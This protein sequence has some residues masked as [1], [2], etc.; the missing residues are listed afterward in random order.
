MVLDFKPQMRIIQNATHANTHVVDAGA[1]VE[2]STGSWSGSSG[3][4][5]PNTN[6]QL[7]SSTDNKPAYVGLLFLVRIK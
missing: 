4:S 5:Q 7:S 1:Q 2:G 3:P 6:Y